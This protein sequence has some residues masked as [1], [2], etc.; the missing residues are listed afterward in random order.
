[1]ILLNFFLQAI[2]KITFYIRFFVGVFLFFHRS[3][4]ILSGKI[5]SKSSE[6]EFVK[7][8]V[9]SSMR[10]LTSFFCTCKFDL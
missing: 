2:A 9:E 6:G 1:M 10:A 4:W 5:L 7:A 8:F 3:Y